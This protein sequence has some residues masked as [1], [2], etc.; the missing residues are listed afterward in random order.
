MRVF[1]NLCAGLD[2]LGVA[3]G[4]NDFRRALRN[5]T[6]PVGVVGKTH[7]LYEHRWQNPILFGA[8]TMSHPL[9]DPTLLE[10]L[11]IRRVLVQGLWMQ[12]MCQPIWGDKVRS[13]PVGIDTD[14]WSPRETQVKDFDVLVYDKVRWKHEEYQRELID[15]I[16]ERLRA[17]GLKVATI[18]YGYYREEEFEALV[19]RCRSMVFLCEHETQGFAY[20]Q[21][22]SCGVPI[23]AWDRGGYWQDPEY[24]PDR[25]KFEPVSS[26]PNWDERCGEKFSGLG[27][28]SNALGR[29]WTGVEAG[30]YA[31]RDFILE[32][33]TLE[34]CAADY[35]R[36]WNEAFGLGA[37]S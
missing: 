28:F 36:N 5:P 6:M 34:R 31:P 25:V 29:F 14:R 22:L 23:L 32:N 4:V 7:V 20:Q 16:L 35:L 27:E 21:V 19:R 9:A 1:L 24:Y 3:Y 10:R 13:C 15:P 8:S 11:P 37:S 17:R 2:R 26:V 33:L 18:R 30:S 12:M